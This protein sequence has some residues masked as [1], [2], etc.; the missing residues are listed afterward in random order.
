MAL[1]PGASVVRRC[2]AGPRR[3]TAARVSLIGRPVAGPKQRSFDA[4]VP[5]QRVTGTTRALPRIRQPA[6]SRVGLTSL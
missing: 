2:A 1:S 4:G 5:E 3:R 6:L